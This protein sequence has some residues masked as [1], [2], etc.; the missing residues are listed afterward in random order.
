M[1][2]EQVFMEIWVMYTELVFM[3]IVVTW[4]AVQYR[5][6]C[7]QWCR[8]LKWAPGQHYIH[9][10]STRDTNLHSVTSFIWNAALM[11]HNDWHI[12]TYLDFCIE[13]T[14]PLAPGPTTGLECEYTV[15]L[16]PFLDATHCIDAVYHCCI[17]S[18]KK[19]VFIMLILQKEG[20][21]WIAVLRI[22]FHVFLMFSF[23]YF[24]TK[25]WVGKK[26]DTTI[27]LS[28]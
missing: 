16:P 7:R 14:C 18:F 13:L 15:P 2:I 6:N 11:S 25:L 24:R 28:L 20:M 10:P 26:Q 22:M 21:R 4:C 9:S 27:L 5:Y 8:K 1:Y 12:I 17:C 3:E 23:K 19:N